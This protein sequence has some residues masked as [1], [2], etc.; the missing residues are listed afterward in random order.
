ME[1]RRQTVRF[2]LLLCRGLVAHV[3]SGVF[4]TTRPDN[5]VMIRILTTLGFVRVGK[6]YSRRNEA[7]VLYV[8]CPTATA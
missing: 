6:P 7:L 2:A 3:G 1:E 4:A 8:R 5:T